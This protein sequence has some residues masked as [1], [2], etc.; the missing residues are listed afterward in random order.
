MLYMYTPSKPKYLMFYAWA[1]LLKIIKG[2]FCIDQK[3]ACTHGRIKCGH[4]TAAKDVQGNWF[5]G[6]TD[7]ED[8]FDEDRPRLV[9][10]VII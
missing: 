6:M 3:I 7:L 10:E 1:L 2:F 4:V 5:S 9:F 8:M